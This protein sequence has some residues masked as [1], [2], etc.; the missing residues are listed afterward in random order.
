MA[1]P[2]L[3]CPDAHCC[4]DV[5]R[6]LNRASESAQSVPGVM[7]AVEV[8]VLE[9]VDTG[10]VTDVIVAA[11]V[12]AERARKTRA[13]IKPVVT[14]PGESPDSFFHLLAA[15]LLNTVESDRSLDTA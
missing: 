4:H 2:M 13:E 10:E 3:H 1:M 7:S 14:A 9:V 5:V 11:F 8:V 15:I 12:T 6:Q